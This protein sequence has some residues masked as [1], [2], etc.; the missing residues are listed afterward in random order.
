MHFATP[1]IDINN[2]CSGFYLCLWYFRPRD[3]ISAQRPYLSVQIYH[4]FKLF[5]L[6]D[7]GHIS[8]PR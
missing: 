7:G 4:F 2:Q 5:N 6:F 8:S 1:I 3:G